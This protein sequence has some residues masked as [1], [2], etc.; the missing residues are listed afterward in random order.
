MGVPVLADVADVTEHDDA[1]YES[2]AILV[3][4][5]LFEKLEQEDV[6]KST[7]VGPTF[8][9][10]EMPSAELTEL[11]ESEIMIERFL[12]RLKSYVTESSFTVASFTSDINT[13][14]TDFAEIAEIVSQAKPS[15]TVWKM[16]ELC[17]KN[18]STM[19]EA[20]ELLRHYI[21]INAPGNRLLYKAI[22]LN[23]RILTLQNSE[24]QLDFKVATN[25]DKV[26][27][28]LR[29][30]YFWNSRLKQV[31]GVRFGTRRVF[32]TYYGRAAAML[33]NLRNQIPKDDAF[34]LKVM[35]SERCRPS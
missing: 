4:S 11:A 15:K 23:V 27:R 5:P 28:Y 35:C 25:P 1:I 19:I 3:V 30:L 34:F 26:L 33:K 17:T 13:L 31:V 10:S 18:L 14:K 32:G 12:K 16:L 21:R 2:S 20:S 6:I 7:I 22:E 9:Q 24:G 29:S 8:G